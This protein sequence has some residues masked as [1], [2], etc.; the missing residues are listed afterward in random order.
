M[1]NLNEVTALVVHFR[2]DVLRNV[3][4]V[5]HELLHVIQLILSLINH[6]FHVCCLALHLKLFKVQLLL[7]YQT[8]AAFIMV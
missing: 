5:S 7:L 1:V 6:I 4:D 3:I 2:V 8:L